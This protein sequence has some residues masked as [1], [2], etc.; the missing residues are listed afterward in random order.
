VVAT[1][2]LE[3][4]GATP[5]LDATEALLREMGADGRLVHLERLAARDASYGTL[6]HPLPARVASALGVERLWSHQAAAID[7]LRGGRSVVVATGTGSGKSLCY[8]AAIAEA[9]GSPVRAGTSLLLF[10]TKALAQ[11]QLRAMMAMKIPRL[12]AATYDGDSG[13]AERA[14]VRRS[15]NVVLTNPEMLHH[16]RV[17]HTAR[18]LRFARRPAAA[19]VATAVR[20]LRRVTDVRLHVGHPRRG[21]PAGHVVERPRRGGGQQRRFAPR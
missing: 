3:L 5:D 17:A 21:G 6:Q 13:Q 15:A 12:A 1:D 2:P 14:W 10:P 8:Q 4:G 18:Y 19:P 20:P 7:L 9:V 16:G 11:D